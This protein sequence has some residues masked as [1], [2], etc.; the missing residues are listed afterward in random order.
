MHVKWLQR[1]RSLEGPALSGS[2]RSDN[3]EGLSLVK[4]WV[5]VF[6]NEDH[7]QSFLKRSGIMGSPV[8]SLSI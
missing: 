3:L 6:Q 5:E 8:I 4:G 7:G 1:L 2:D